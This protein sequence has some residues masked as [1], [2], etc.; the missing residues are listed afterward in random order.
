MKEVISIT[1]QYE[2]KQKVLMEKLQQTIQKIQLRQLIKV[3]TFNNRFSMH[4]KQPYMGRRCQLEK[5]KM[6]VAQF[7]SVAQ[8]CP[9]LCDSMNHSTIPSPTPGVH[10]DSCPLCPTLCNPMDCSPPSSMGFPWQEHWSGLPFPSP[11]DLPNP[12]VE[13]RSPELQADQH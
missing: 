11:G 1:K 12:G 10:S 5:A 13:P 2:V 7:S 6:L 3:A 4:T 9:T 8:S